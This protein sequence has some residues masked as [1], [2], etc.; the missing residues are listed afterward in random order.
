MTARVMNSPGPNRSHDDDNSDKAATK[1]RNVETETRCVYPNE[2]RERNQIYTLLSI[3][4]SVNEQEERPWECVNGTGWEEAVSKP[5][6]ILKP[7]FF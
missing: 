7:H 1:L 5:I 6:L 4:N 3:S 2:K